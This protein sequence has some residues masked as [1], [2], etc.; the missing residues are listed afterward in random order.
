MGDTRNF[1]W[2]NTIQLEKTY[3]Q[4]KLAV[5]R[6]ADRLWV[7]NVGDIKP[8]EL[9]ISHWFDLAYDI[10]AFSEKS[11]PQWLESWAARTF[12]QEN[13]KT[14][15]E[16]MDKYSMLANMRKFENVEPNSYSIINYEEADHVIAQW[17]DLGKKAQAVYD[18]LDAL[19]QPSFFQIVLHPVLAGGNFI[20]VQVSGARNQ[21][22]S[23]QGRNSANRWFQRV[24]DGMKIDHNLTARYHSI[25]NSKWNHIMD[26]T[27]LG[28]QGYW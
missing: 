28:Y 21:A 26:Q 23:G 15:A 1:K 24:I 20:D 17:Q 22:Y 8:Y 3:E 7:V 5:D 2:I 4:M 14:I 9:P 13:A 12:D 19:Q 10:D 18:S 16:I 6:D 27:H 25:L 11:T